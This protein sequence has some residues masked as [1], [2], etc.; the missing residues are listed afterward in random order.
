MESTKREKDMT[1]RATKKDL[2]VLLEDQIMNSE[3]NCIFKTH[4][5][6]FFPKCFHVSL[7]SSCPN[8]TVHFYTKTPLGRAHYSRISNK[9]VDD[10]K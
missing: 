10:I 3:K 8:E 9:Q 4:Q 6:M 7:F 5:S 2:F 1:K